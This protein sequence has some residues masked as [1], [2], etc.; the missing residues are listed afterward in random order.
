MSVPQNDPPKKLVFNDA[1][2]NAFIEGRPEPAVE[3]KVAAYLDARPELLAKIASNS[4]EVFLNLLKS[5][6]LQ[7]VS[8]ASLEKVYERK[9]LEKWLDR[10]GHC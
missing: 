8:A 5:A 9:T 10:W 7:S 2:L 4:G 6:K 1:L 3:Q